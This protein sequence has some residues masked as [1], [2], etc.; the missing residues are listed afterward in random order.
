MNSQLNVILLNIVDQTLIRRFKYV[1]HILN[2]LFRQ[3]MVLSFETNIVTEIATAMA[4]LLH[5]VL[6]C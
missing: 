5:L 6:T 3:F 4:S 1:T 2:V